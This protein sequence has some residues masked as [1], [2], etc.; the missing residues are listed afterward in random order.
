[1][2]HAKT[3]VEVSRPSVAT[4]SMSTPA[5]VLRTSAPPQVT[6][7]SHRHAT[8]PAASQPR[9]ARGGRSR[10]QVD[11]CLGSAATPFKA[12]MVQQAARVHPSFALL[13]KLVWPAT[14]LSS[15]DAHSCM[16]GAAV[17]AP[18]FKG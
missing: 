6:H 13:L 15:G 18:V 14:Q 5:V 3:K 4:F 11:L 2:L 17:A 16:P 1:M 10:P 9:P 8:L 7:V 12:W